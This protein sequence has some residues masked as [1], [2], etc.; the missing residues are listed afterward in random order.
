MFRVN[1]TRLVGVAL[2]AQVLL[3]AADGPAANRI[4]VLTVCQ[5]LR[6]PGRYAGQNVIVVGRSV[7]TDE[8]SWLDE[9]CGLKLLIQGRSFSATISTAYAA[10]D[11]APPPQL[12]EGFK[13]DKSLLRQALAEVRKTTR[14]DRGTRWDAVYGRLETTVPR[15]VTLGNG[16]VYS[17]FGYGH[18]SAAPAQLIFPVNGF[19]RLE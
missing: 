2:C 10:S 6:E 9:N 19:R 13:W 16:Q 11:F 14:L 15:I 17:T 4:P 7:G 3:G 12:P 1:W 5:A 18:L 8:G